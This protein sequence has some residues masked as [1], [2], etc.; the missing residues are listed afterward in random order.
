MYPQLFSMDCANIFSNAR[1]NYFYKLNFY[2]GLV[3][4]LQ[5][6]FSQRPVRKCD[7][8]R[9]LFEFLKGIPQDSAVVEKLDSLLKEMAGRVRKLQKN[10][11]DLEKNESPVRGEIR[12]PV[13]R[14]ISLISLVDHFFDADT[15]SESVVILDS[16]TISKL[17]GFW[18][19]ALSQPIFNALTELKM[20]W[21]GREDNILEKYL[22]T[23]S[24]FESLL[25]NSL[26]SG[27]TY[28]Y[29]PAILWIINRTDNMTSMDLMGPIHFLNRLRFAGE[30]W[31]SAKFL[32][33]G[34]YELLMDI[35]A[36]YKI[37]S[38]ELVSKTFKLL[39]N[40][41]AKD[42]SEQAGMIWNAYFDHLWSGDRKKDFQFNNVSSN[43]K[44]KISS[45]VAT[46]LNAPTEIDAAI[47]EMFDMDRY[48]RSK[49]E[50]MSVWQLPHI[51]AYNTLAG[52]NSAKQDLNRALLEKAEQMGVE[53]MHCHGDYEH[54]FG[55]R[56]NGRIYCKLIPIRTFPVTGFLVNEDNA[57]VA[58]PFENDTDSMNDSGRV[59]FSLEEKV[60]L[61]IGI[62]TFKDT[63]NIYVS[64]RNCP[65]FGFDGRFG[66][67]ARNNVHLKDLR[68]NLKRFIKP[69]PVTGQLFLDIEGV[70]PE[71]CIGRPH[72]RPIPPA[73]SSVLRPNESIPA[74][75]TAANLVWR[76]ADSNNLT[77]TANA[78][79]TTNPIGRLEEVP[80]AGTSN[81]EL[82]A[83]LSETL[84][85]NE[86]SQNEVI[87]EVTPRALGDVRIE[88]VEER[89]E[90]VE[91]LDLGD[92]NDFDFGDNDENVNEN[93]R[94]VESNGATTVARKRRRVQMYYC[95]FIVYKLTS[96]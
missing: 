23:I 30:A 65:E 18:V 27:S 41:Q 20:N 93:S 1:D 21:I 6:D 8:A 22:P 74:P 64:I 54:F 13:N 15:I 50:R 60:N 75:L 29:T 43:D 42:I 34:S 84:R 2:N 24:V 48:S 88:V 47:K 70:R 35:A 4:K 17:L 51:L 77:T 59:P 83:F 86:H 96:F 78:N 90:I 71:D 16:V 63:K 28:S 32:I 94:F 66:G 68:R 9:K 81:T 37:K 49:K 91:E 45:L 69:S 12:I 95:C 85:P 58:V 73:P 44:F 79:L 80:E 33:N 89:I 56:Q 72:L 92:L 62:N 7:L 40:I 38:A 11:T 52:T 14:A 53:Y 57:L 61:V 19:S 5:I 55:N 46:V 25:M 31:N 67:K 26:F 36:R 82:E 3:D 39:K 10:I 87:R 76:R